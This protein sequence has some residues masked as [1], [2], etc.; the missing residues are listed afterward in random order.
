MLVSMT[1]PPPGPAAAV[2]ET[3]ISVVTMIG[4]RAYKLLKPVRLPFLDNRRR[5]DRRAACRRETDV[6]RRFAP[7]VYLGVLD[8]VGEDGE[9]CDHLIAMRR[10]PGDRRLS[11]LLDDP[12]A[13]RLVEEVARWLAAV[14]AAAPRGPEIDAA[15]TPE[16]VGGLWREGLDQLAAAAAG[17]IDPAEVEEVRRLALRYVGGRGPLFARRIA[18]GWVRDGHGDLLADDVFCLDDGP[19]VLDCLAFDDRLRFGDVLLDVAFLAMDLEARGHA[20]LSELLLASWGRATGE[21]HEPSLAH[22]YVAYRAHV[23]AKVACLRAAQGDAAA[24]ADARRLQALCVDRLERGRVR[25]VLVGGAP[26]T[27]KTTVARALADARDWTVI[28]SDAVRKERE[29]RPATPADPGP[30]AEGRYAPAATA[31]V[32]A[33]M[34]ERARPVLGMGRSV[35]LDASWADPGRRAAARALADSCRADLVEIRCTA[36]PEVADARIL[37]RRRAGAGPSDATPEIAHRLAAAFAPWP[38]AAAVPT[39]RERDASVAAALAHAGR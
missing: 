32:Y 1:S 37:A 4:D 6:N 21:D 25:L 31:A 33:E 36:P 20:G 19:R 15:G 34:L 30:Y 22:H 23:R 24:A 9:P 8:V 26:G 17:V 18:G 3:H 11:R 10:M 28:G 27:G 14:H 7:D 38:E 35:V 39:D 2:V 13:P 16:S 29:G 5:E 12:E